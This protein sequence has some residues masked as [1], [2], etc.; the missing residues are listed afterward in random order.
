M[1][2]TRETVDAI[3]IGDYITRGAYRYIITGI[4]EYTRGKAFTIT[5]TRDGMTVYA[6]PACKLYGFTI[7]RADD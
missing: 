3:R 6:Y 1:K 7:E 2:L 4:V 5:D